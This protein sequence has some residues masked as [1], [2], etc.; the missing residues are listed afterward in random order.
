[1]KLI[2]SI[3]L[4][5]ALMFVMVGCGQGTSYI[6]SYNNTK[7]PA[8]IY[9]Y[10]MNNNMYQAATLVVDKTKDPL[11]Q[12]IDGKKGSE[13]V[14]DKTKED[15]LAYIATEA[16]SE[17]LNITIEKE[18]V[19]AI[20][21]SLNE[22]WENDKSRYEDKGISKDSVLKAVLSQQKK[23]KVLEAYY[24]EG[25]EKSATEEELKKYYVDS[26]A[27]INQ[28]VVSKSIKKNDEL[29]PASGETLA[30]I[31][32]DAKRYFDMLNGGEDFDTVLYTSEKEA[33][34]AEGLEA[35]EAHEHEDEFTH[36]TIVTKGQPYFP[37]AYIS[38]IFGTEVG[39]AG[40][41][42]DDNM[43]VVFV[44]KDIN[45]NPEDF[46]KRKAQMGLFMKS[47]VIDS[48]LAEAAL[49]MGATLND[50]ALKRYDPKGF[51]KR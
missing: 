44:R 34:A 8:G 10:F 24:G 51:S 5:L 28:I 29:I 14:V 39:K 22:M 45:A 18:T 19:D 32:E 7:I 36:D 42:E 9:L 43:Y 23:A 15:L 31:K 25:G 17:R 49:T 37:E 12:T 16:E 3:A 41:Y 47:E 46:E 4:I 1:M 6:A 21:S 40:L 35:P 38:Q 26:Y 13:W 50:A 11:T 30:K 48:E 2:K 20:T 33:A 27:R